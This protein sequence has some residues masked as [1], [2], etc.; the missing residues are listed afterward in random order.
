MYIIVYTNRYTG[1]CTYD[2]VDLI[3]CTVSYIP[4]SIYNNLHALFFSPYHMYSV[5]NTYWYIQYCTNNKVR[6]IKHI[7]VG[8]ILYILIGIHD[9][10]DMIRWDE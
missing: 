8:T 1:H 6:S 7:N 2:K 9:M 4:T 3:I 5:L 10:V